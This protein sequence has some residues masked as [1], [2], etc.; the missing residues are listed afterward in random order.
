MF[1]LSAYVIRT[2]ALCCSQ[3]SLRVLGQDKGKCIVSMDKSE[4]KTVFTTY[5]R[6]ATFSKVSSTQS[7]RKLEVSPRFVTL[8]TFIT[9]VTFI[10]DTLARVKRHLHPGMWATSIDLSE[11]YHHIPFAR[12][13]RYILCFQLGQK[14]QYLVLPFGLSSAPWAFD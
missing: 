5:Q 7:I 10:M 12:S 3:C 1:H 2:V 11:A 14:H 4:D 8:N 6:R 13:T 9:S